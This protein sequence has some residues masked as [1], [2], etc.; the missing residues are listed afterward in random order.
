MSLK[1]ERSEVRSCYLFTWRTCEWDS[2]VLGDLH[3]S[4]SMCFF[5]SLLI[6][7][8]FASFFILLCSFVNHSFIFPLICFC[9]TLSLIL[10]S[11]IQ[12]SARLLS[13]SNS[14]HSSFFCCSTCIFSF[15]IYIISYLFIPS[16]I[17]PCPFLL[18]LVYFPHY[19][20][21]LPSYFLPSLC[22][23]FPF[24]SYM[25]SFFSSFCSSLF[26]IFNL[27]T[28]N[29]GGRA[30]GAW[31]CDRLPAG[32]AGSNPPGIMAVCLL[33]MLIVIS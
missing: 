22:F 29:R 5:F 27:T 8:L 13:S 3:C 15:V 21:P 31:I 20:F 33:S 18:S 17:L 4:I 10:W 2:P 14:P 16:S 32:I 19:L 30:T 9:I 7:S 26:H 1:I 23:P 25:R 11:V 24:S 6:S 28:A 12:S